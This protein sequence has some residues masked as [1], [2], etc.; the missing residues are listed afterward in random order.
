MF[1]TTISSRIAFFI[2]EV[3][4]VPTYLVLETSIW[5]SDLLQTDRL[6]M[7]VLYETACTCF[8]TGDSFLAKNNSTIYYQDYKLNKLCY[9][10]EILFKIKF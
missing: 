5:S 7:Q 8:S 3:N 2:P 1:V 9:S 6:P 10:N 4:S